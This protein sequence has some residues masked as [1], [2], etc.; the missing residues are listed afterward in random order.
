MPPTSPDEIK[1]AW[2]PSSRVAIQDGATLYPRKTYDQWSAVFGAAE[3]LAKQ[4]N[5][6]KVYAIVDCGQD[7]DIYARVMNHWSASAI[8]L[9]DG[10]PE[11]AL[12]KLS[13]RLVQLNPGIWFEAAQLAEMQSKGLA[14]CALSDQWP[15]LSWLFSESSPEALAQHLRSLLNGVLLDDTAQPIGEV[16]VRHYD[17]R[18]LPGFLE[19]LTTEQYTNAL[20]P[21]AGWGVWTRAQD[22]RVWERP[23]TESLFAQLSGGANR[24]TLQQ[25]A[26]LNQATAVDRIDA[27][28]EEQYWPLR[29]S[30]LMA[31]AIAQRFLNLR[32]NERFT[33]LTAIL[34]RAFKS[35]VSEDGDLLL[36][37]SIALGIHKQFDTHP[38]VAECLKTCG[39]QRKSFKDAVAGLPANVWDEIEQFP[40]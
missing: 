5:N 3:R 28:I 4:S 2:P 36:Y 25:H 34:E 15:C 8:S 11:A 21:I 22:W 40:A 19:M 17:A 18:V 16:M 31:E 6:L 33:T 24:Y 9:F 14:L 1:I 26:M 29:E 20:T 30:D 12:E 32:P 39:A 13:P 23:T 35:G 37:A 27:L 10:T 38:A 7:P